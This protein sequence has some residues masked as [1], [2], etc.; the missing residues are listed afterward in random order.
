MKSIL[1]ITLLLCVM[2]SAFAQDKEEG[3]DLTKE[4]PD[5]SDTSNDK[6]D[7]AGFLFLGDSL[8]AVRKTRLIDEETFLTYSQDEN[9]LILDTR[10]RAAFDDIHVAGAVH[11]NFSDFTEQKLAEKIPNKNTRILIYCN[12]NFESDRAS[13]FNKRVDLALNIPTFINLHGYGYENVFE[14]GV[15]LDE[16]ET[17]IPLEVRKE[18][19]SR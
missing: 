6:I 16:E 7:F 10:S 2:L 18:E 5:V 8:A 4:E 1:L 9:T 14:L 19:L 12:N 15:Y 3:S 17:R 11:L 13:L